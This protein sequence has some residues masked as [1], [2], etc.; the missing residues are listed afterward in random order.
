MKQKTESVGRAV[1]V[2]VLRRGCEEEGCGKWLPDAAMDAL[3]TK[4]TEFAQGFCAS[5]W[6]RWEIGEG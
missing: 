3:S 4:R 2:L 1:F 5:V 6:K